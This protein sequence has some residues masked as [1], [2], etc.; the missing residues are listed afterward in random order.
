LLCLLSLLALAARATDLVPA[1]LSCNDSTGCVI[2]KG[3]CEYRAV[4]RDRAKAALHVLTE[5]GKV[6]D[7]AL[8]PEEPGGR[9][10]C[11]GGTCVITSAEA[12][13]SGSK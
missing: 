11:R 10:A 5:A 13:I 3:P 8:P 7:C 4:R 1:F 9:A 12:P 6:M 2:I